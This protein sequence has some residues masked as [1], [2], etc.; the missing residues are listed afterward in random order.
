MT[1]RLA[2]LFTRLV[3]LIKK[4][5]PQNIAV[6]RILVPDRFSGPKA[7]SVIYRVEDSFS[8]QTRK[9]TQAYLRLLQQ[10]SQERAMLSNQEPTTPVISPPETV[11]GMKTLDRKLFSCTVSIPAIKIPS[12]H[13][14]AITKI[15]KSFTFK[16]QRV[17]PIAEL[18]KDDSQHASH[19][20]CLLNP[21]KVKSGQDFSAE[22]AEKLAEFDVDVKDVFYFDVD[23]GYDNWTA[24]ELLRAVLPAESEGVS[25]YSIIGH[26]AHL[27]LKSEV[28]DY[29]HLIGEVIL[30]KNPSVKTV[31]NKLNTIDNTFRNFQMELL[32]GEDNFITRAK[33]NGSVFE[34]DFAKVYWNPRL[35]TEHQRVVDLINK[36]DILYDVFA[37][38]GPFA[39]PVAKKGATVL[40]NDLNPNSYDALVNNVKLNKVKGERLKAF[41]LDGREFIKT[42]VKEDLVSR[43]KRSVND[44]H[45]KAG[46]LISAAAEKTD[47]K[48]QEPTCGDSEAAESQHLYIAMN[49]P[50]L[51]LEFLDA[52]CGLLSDFPSESQGDC[53]V[54]KALPTVLCYCFSKSDNPEADVRSRA[55]SIM[56][57]ELPADSKVRSVR[58]VAPNK[59]MMCLVFRLSP[60]VLFSAGVK[61]TEVKDCD[62][63][64]GVDD[65]PPSK[66][67]RVSEAL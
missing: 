40:A 22:D 61:D 50:A 64:L 12:K 57:H 62:G 63:G 55:E 10:F 30:D 49:L 1:S 36:D 31:V 54:L 20:L 53:D 48:K 11:R 41:N 46:D 34:M 39:I 17:K 13:I 27:N 29:K 21:E 23:L 25:S 52:Y 18:A 33:E 9:I 14:G 38:V 44:L 59:E 15:L 35:S 42:V 5:P 43:L 67:Q 58:N 65:Q 37:G 24:A 66:K 32:A 16:I 4:S 19:K 47:G 7:V 45:N 28:M 60:E 8:F 2:S 56:G 6:H 3:R 51:A 26:I